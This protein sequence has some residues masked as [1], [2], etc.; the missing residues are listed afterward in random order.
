MKEAK[1]NTLVKLRNY[2]DGEA[3][4]PYEYFMLLV[5][6]VNT[7]SIGLETSKNI[8]ESFRNVLFWIDKICL[9]IFIAE[10]IFKAIVYNRDF[11]GENRND[12]NGNEYFHVNRWNISDLIIV[13]V[14]LISSLSYFAIFRVFRVFRS[15]KVIKAIHS[16]RIIKSFKLVNEVSSLRTIFKGLLK[17]IPGIIAT[18]SF[19]AIFAYAYAIIGTN[20]FSE[21]FPQFFGSLGTS[22]LTLCQVTTF[23]SWFSGITRPI[24]QVYPWAWIYFVSYAF[25]AASVIMNVIVGIIVDSM[26][27]ERERQKAKRN[28]QKK[29][30]SLETLSKQIQEL[31]TQ[32]E[33]LENKLS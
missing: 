5:I 3:D 30:V 19:L 6:I 11:F 25:I 28:S 2:V 14:S 10:L 8:S 13:V 1:N 4:T 17:A 18:F 26:G 9:C 33:K 27:N 24:T 16:L 7:V 32:I 29:D 21:D 12:E 23:D 31:Q 22:I 15:F 20:I